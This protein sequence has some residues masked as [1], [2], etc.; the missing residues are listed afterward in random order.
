MIMEQVSFAQFGSWVA[1]MLIV[2]GIWFQYRQTRASERPGP[3]EIRPQPLMVQAA[4]SVVTQSILDQV[5]HENER[6]IRSL[7]EQ[8]KAAA[9]VSA[10]SRRR[11][12]DKIEQ[13]KT[14]LSTQTDAVR[15]ELS[16]EIQATPSQVIALLKNTGALDRRG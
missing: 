6:R 7:E 12:Y 11:I 8:V 13:V 2:L 5:Q 10:E 4:E 1:C 16:K 15:R 3:T 14:D 9:E